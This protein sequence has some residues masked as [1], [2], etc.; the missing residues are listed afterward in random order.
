MSKTI[1]EIRR[2]IDTIDNRILDLLEERAECVRR[3]GAEKKKKNMPVILPDREINLI[4]KLLKR[5][6]GLFSK[7]SLIRIW[8]EIIGAAALLQ[9][10]VKISV[11]AEDDQN[12][13]MLWD[14][15]KDYA[16]APISL[17]RTT[18]ALSSFAM[19][20]E[21]DAD[22]AVVPW[23]GDESRNAW[24]VHIL[25]E[26]GDNA[27]RVIARLPL[28]DKDEKVAPEHQALVIGRVPYRDSG[29]D[30][31]FVV[32]ELDSDISRAR[33]VEEAGKNG[34]DIRSVHNCGGADPQYRYYLLEVD[35]YVDPEKNHG[36]ALLKALNSESGRC[37]VI[38][39]YPAPPV[40][41]QKKAE[42]QKKSA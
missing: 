21:G 35:G 11:T 7:E 22:M 12:A 34:W 14:L 39:G 25:N 33:L 6:E 4:R 42:K 5:H 16:A 15:A 8:R 19:V 40:L 2:Q 20:R 26:A 29:D 18:N 24:W 38:G 32:L 9:K 41:E 3:I 27:I 17:Q 37:T 1:E 31:S 28:Y 30:R 23:P 36:D 13:L 10:D